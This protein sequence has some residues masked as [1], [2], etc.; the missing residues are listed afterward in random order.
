MSAT[1]L[2][3][4]RNGFHRPL[5]IATS[6]LSHATPN[7]SW[8]HL[9]KSALVLGHIPVGYQEAC[10]L[11]ANVTHDWRL[12]KQVRH[13]LRTWCWQIFCDKDL[14]F[15]QTRHLSLRASSWP[16]QIFSLNFVQQDCLSPVGV[17]FSMQASNSLM[18]IGASWS[19]TFGLIMQ[20][21]ATICNTIC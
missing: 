8:L 2:G 7:T 3:L 17:K 5:T 13:F 18:D 1:L 12:R 14:S 4:W 16:Q 19:A 20:H 15:Q 6:C 11:V 21:Y 10:L 9:H